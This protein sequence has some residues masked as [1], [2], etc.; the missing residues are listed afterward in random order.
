MIC[1]EARWHTEMVAKYDKLREGSAVTPR[2]PRLD[3][4]DTLHHVMV[5]GLGADR[6]LDQPLPELG[7]PACLGEGEGR[8]GGQQGGVQELKLRT[9]RPLSEKGAYV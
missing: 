1:G 8:L 4:A 2:G 7:D 3:A 6:R 9:R 5:R